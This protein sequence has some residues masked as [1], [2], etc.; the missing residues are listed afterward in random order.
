MFALKLIALL[1][2]MACVWPAA[3]AQ[4]LSAEAAA[5]LRAA[6]FAPD[7]KY[8]SEPS[9][10][11]PATPDMALYKPEGAGPF[12]AL[13][14]MHQCGGL[15]NA[16]RGW[17]N[18][19]VLEW[20]RS[21]VARGYVVA[22]VDSLGPRNVDTVCLGPRNGVNFARGARDAL[23]AG[24][25]VAALPYVDP[26]RVAVM[27]FSWGAMVSVVASSSEWAGALGEG[28]RF[29]AAV[30]MYPGCFTIRPQNA[31]AY[32]IVQPDIDRPLLM[33]MGGLDTETP[34][35]DCA[36]RLAP[37]QGRAP[38]TSHLYP[39]ATHCWDCRNLD[40]FTKIDA[41]GSRV[42]YRYN[43]AVTRDSAERAFDFL[44]A[45]MAR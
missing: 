35:S 15:R 28:F 8:P 25:H 45:R 5:I 36:S 6:Q 44:A 14:L 42:T 1:F 41:R 37:L 32:E 12:P 4:S 9:P 34:A 38:I 30:A 10:L 39:D 19:S 22:V 23:L 27:G 2:V 31:P 16:A 26:Q 43:E 33:L 3:Q 21:A 29:R 18:L 13:V 24:K 40:G 17:Q 11:P 7:L 20:E